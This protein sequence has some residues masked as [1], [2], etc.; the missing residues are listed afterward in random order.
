MS[1]EGDLAGDLRLADALGRL[2]APA[3]PPGLAERIARNATSVP[4]LHEPEQVART[5]V[6]PP[7]APFDARPVRARRWL[8]S[9]A[10]G[11]AIAATLA[12]A[13]L[14]AS[15]GSDRP[16][17]APVVARNDLA[18]P[19]RPVVVAPPVLAQAHDPA[20]VTSAPH[21]KPAASPISGPAVPALVD[22]APH[23]LAQDGRSDAPTGAVPD[24]TAPPAV[25]VAVPEVRPAE[26][27][28]MG[29]PDLDDT[30][31]PMA[32]PGGNRE[33]GISGAGAPDISVPS[34]V[35]RGQLGGRGAGAMPRF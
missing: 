4:Q 3:I 26:Q 19:A 20:P 13:W 31:A 15:G 2:P 35:P 27:E 33:L 1:E 22:S 24:G 5:A 25:A 28:L 8:P 14:Q 30:G 18:A 9:A 17:T 34:P 32:Q 10:A 12:V 16:K 29:P 11:A 7:A 23:G 6:E 21:P